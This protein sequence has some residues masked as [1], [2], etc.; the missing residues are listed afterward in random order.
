MFL[1]KYL[2]ENIEILNLA[3]S[4][5]DI[6]HEIKGLDKV[7]SLTASPWILKSKINVL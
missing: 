6:E 1:E 4:N 5:I 2:T 7:N 3:I